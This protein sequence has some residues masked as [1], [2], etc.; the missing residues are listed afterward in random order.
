MRV[1]IS[2][3]TRALY[4]NFGEAQQ[5]APFPQHGPTLAGGA[6]EGGGSGG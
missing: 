5:L 6:R 1:D 2:T 3:P 4:S